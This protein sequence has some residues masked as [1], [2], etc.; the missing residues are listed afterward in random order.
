[1]NATMT[2]TPFLN[3]EGGPDYVALGGY[4]L[5]VISELL[6]F[7]R[8]GK[9]N[10]GIIH[11][12]VCILKGSRCMADKL[13]GVLETNIENPPKVKQSGEIGVEIVV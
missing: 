12:L 10:N 7:F 13:L 1:M 8:K 3:A 6:P 2:Y 5:F 11:T 4:G 9:E